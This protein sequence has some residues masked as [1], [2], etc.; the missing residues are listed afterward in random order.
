MVVW[1]VYDFYEHRQNLMSQNHVQQPIE[2]L[3]CMSRGTPSSI[4]LFHTPIVIHQIK[5]GSEAY[6]RTQIK[7]MS[8]LS[9]CNHFNI[10]SGHWTDW[11]TIQRVIRWTNSNSDN[12]AA[13]GQFEM[14]SMFTLWDVWLPHDCALIIWQIGVENQSQVRTFIIDMINLSIPFTWRTS[15][16]LSVQFLLMLK[17]PRRA[18][19]I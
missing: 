15:G 7:E 17:N 5:L 8:T 4:P 10:S 6:R 13:R 11:S 12:C 14:T 9:V 19:T 1:F 18:S 3:R 16:F 2:Y